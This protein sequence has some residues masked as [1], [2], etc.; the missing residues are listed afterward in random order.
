M[1][2]YSKITNIYTFNIPQYTEH[3]F[4]Y[5]IAKYEHQFEYD[6]A[7]YEHQFE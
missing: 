1:Y 3:Q 7:K 6:I 4:E 2:K 5:D